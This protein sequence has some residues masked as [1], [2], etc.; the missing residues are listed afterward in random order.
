MH[1]NPDIT[2]A[3]KNDE[4][5]AGKPGHGSCML[6]RAA[7]HKY[8]VA[9]KIDPVI[10]RVPSFHFGMEYWMQGLKHILNDVGDGKRAVLLMALYWPRKTDGGD[11]VFKGIDGSDG[12][13]TIRQKLGD[14]LRKLIEKGVTPVTGTG[15]VGLVCTPP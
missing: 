13:D 4:F 15:N 8:G 10:V 5:G 2:D 7:G 12:Y 3:T 11:F 6:T 14:L 1:T 9:K